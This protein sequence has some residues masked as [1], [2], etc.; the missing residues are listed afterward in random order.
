MPAAGGISFI[1]VSQPIE[2]QAE[3]VERVKRFKAG[4]VASDSN[5]RPDAT[6]RD[7]LA[8]RDRTGHTTMAV[9]DDGTPT[10]KLLGMLTSRDYRLT[11]TP[12]DTRVADLMTPFA[13]LVY[14][15]EGMTP[16]RGERPDLE[17]QAELPARDHEDRQPRATWCSARTTPSTRRT[18]T[19]WSTGTSAWWSARASTRATTRERVPALVEAGADVLC[20]DSSDGF[21]EWQAETIAWIKEDVRPR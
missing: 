3:M 7:V 20:I 13:D 17:A 10:G 8:L 11:T 6:L 9:T 5:L 21:S 15:Q 12:P 4:F 16:L 18:P 2:Q 19:S 14:G 1:F